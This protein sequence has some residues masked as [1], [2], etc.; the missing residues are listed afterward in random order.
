M[1]VRLVHSDP[2]V[3]VPG[4]VTVKLFVPSKFSESKV[5]VV[6]GINKL[7]ELPKQIVA[8]DAVTEGTGVIA[9]IVSVFV[10]V[11]A[12]VHGE[13]A[14]AVKVRVTDPAVISAATW[15]ISSQV[16]E[17]AL[18]NVPVPLEVHTTVL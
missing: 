9:F 14:L 15:V 17:L 3:V 5:E 12:T 7:L 18:A 10:D 4:F 6:D 8:G 11:A 16:N 1:L 2:L 13:V